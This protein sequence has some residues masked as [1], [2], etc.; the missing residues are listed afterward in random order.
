MGLQFTLATNV[1][2]DENELD[3]LWAKMSDISI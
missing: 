1:D 2:D 3:C